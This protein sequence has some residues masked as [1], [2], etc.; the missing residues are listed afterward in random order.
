M[1]LVLDGVVPTELRSSW[2]FWRSDGRAS[3]RGEGCA[4]G[5][6]GEGLA[7]PIEVGSVLLCE[8][9][10]PAR[11]APE[12]SMR[13]ED[14]RSWGGHDSLRAIRKAMVIGRAEVRGRATMKRSWHLQPN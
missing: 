14:S 8:R 1:V 7:Q 12:A 4:R 5:R 9:V 10:N 11:R 2:C 3:I 6:A 13:G